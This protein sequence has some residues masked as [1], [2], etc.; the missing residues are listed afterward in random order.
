MYLGLQ[1][2]AK[3]IWTLRRSLSWAWSKGSVTVY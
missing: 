3:A 2:V 1:A